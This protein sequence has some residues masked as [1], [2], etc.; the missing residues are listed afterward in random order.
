[1]SWISPSLDSSH[2]FSQ[3]YLVAIP[4]ESEAGTDP[5]NPDTDGDGLNDGM[6]IGQGSDPNDRADTV[7]VR[8]VAVTGDL[9]EG[10]PKEVNETVVIPAGTTVYVGV[11]VHSDE[12]PTWT[13]RQS[14]YKTANNTNFPNFFM[15]KKEI[16]E[17]HNRNLSLKDMKLLSIRNQKY[18]SKS[19][20]KFAKSSNENSLISSKNIHIHTENNAN[21]SESKNKNVSQIKT[22]LIHSGKKINLNL[23]LNI[24]INNYLDRSHSNKKNTI[25]NNLRVNSLNKNDLN[26]N[27]ENNNNNVVDETQPNENFNPDDFSI[28]KQIGEGTF[29]K[30]Y[31]S[32]WKE[33][34]KKYAMKKMILKNENEIT[35]NKIQTDLVHNFLKKTNSKGVIKIFGS[36]CKKINNEYNFYVLMEL[37]ERDWEKEI[38]ERKDSKQYYT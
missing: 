38:K 22:K 17:I 3:S 9:G 36:Q 7:P 33:N 4:T 37:A 31:C 8:W 20:L 34:K 10:V 23:N 18:I 27:N 16:K 15:K 12:Y 5:A 35:R 26:I 1:M 21:N 29:G 19:K 13:G 30:I 32:E 6:E 24:N 2:S 25:E 14:E 28:I 11:F